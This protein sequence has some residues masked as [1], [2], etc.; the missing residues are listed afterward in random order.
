M[1][2]RNALVV[3]ATLSLPSH[4]EPSH[5]VPAAAV[6][7]VSHPAQ[8]ITVGIST[9]LMSTFDAHMI[10]KSG[11]GLRAD[12]DLAQRGPFLFG[13]SLGV[14]TE[15]LSLFDQIR[16]RDALCLGY[17]AAAKRLGRNELRATLGAGF[18]VTNATSTYAT[19]SS[20]TF[21]TGVG[22]LS[23]TWAIDLTPG[24]ALGVGPELTIYAQAFHEPGALGI[25]ERMLDVG[26]RTSLSW[27]R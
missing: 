1:S 11:I 5:E 14:G 15:S 3:L 6:A 13:A 26:M 10:L 8:R 17:V 9:S 23:L 7:T 12:V 16:T 18:V 25:T 21:V 4:A 19:S 22:D 20:S 24:L 27:T 2:L